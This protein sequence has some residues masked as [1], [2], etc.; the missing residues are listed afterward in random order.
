M[1]QGDESSTRRCSSRCGTEVNPEAMGQ[2]LRRAFSTVLR[3]VGR[4]SG[5]GTSAFLVNASASCSC[6]ALP[7]PSQW[8]LH[9]SLS[10]SHCCNDSL[11]SWQGQEMY[12]VTVSLRFFPSPYI[13]SWSLGLKRASCRKQEGSEER[14][15]R[16]FT[17]KTPEF[18][19]VC[20]WYLSPG[21]SLNSPSPSLP[22]CGGT[23][24]SRVQTAVTM[25]CRHGGQG[26]TDSIS[27]MSY[28]QGVWER[29]TGFLY[30]EAAFYFY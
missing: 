6:L 3:W 17:G 15:Q 21:N 25:S 1:S 10:G 18:P 4:T 24:S 2:S 27:L 26:R 22:S 12:T 20:H 19:Q 7:A 14:R 8:S 11:G 16:R 29:A 9:F 28:R 5:S 13:T 30:S 23:H